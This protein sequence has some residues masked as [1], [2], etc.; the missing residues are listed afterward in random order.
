MARFRAEEAVVRV[1]GER[2]ARYIGSV[3]FHGDTLRVQVKSAS[4]RQNLMMNR[5]AYTHAI[6]HEAGAQVVQDMVFC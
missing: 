1:I 3:Q 6:N 5:M 4:L 2:Y